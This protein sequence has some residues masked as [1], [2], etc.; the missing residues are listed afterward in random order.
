MI[1]T[2]TPTRAE[3]ELLVPGRRAGHYLCFF[4][5]HVL[6]STVMEILEEHVR[7]AGP[8]GGVQLSPA[9]DELASRE[10]YLAIARLGWRY[11]VGVRYG[12]LVAQLALALAGRDRDE[13][14]SQLLE[15]LAH[16]EIQRERS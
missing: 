8:G 1:E 14:L 2:P 6:T 16:R 5:M 10:R 12:L 13:V 11:D 15:L 3:A 7:A 4:G 9:L